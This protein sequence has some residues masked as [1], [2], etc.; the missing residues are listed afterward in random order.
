MPIEVS[1]TQFSS[2]ILLLVLLVS[3][4]IA[5]YYGLKSGDN[6]SV[7][8]TEREAV[9]FAGVISLKVRVQ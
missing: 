9:S 4:I 3:V 1:Q 2:L 7:E 8:D 6:Y 5:V